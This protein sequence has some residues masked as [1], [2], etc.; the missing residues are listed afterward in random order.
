MTFVYEFDLKISEVYL[1]TQNQLSRARLLK[2]RALQ[3][4][5]H[6]ERITT[7][8]RALCIIKLIMTNL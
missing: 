1:H 8:W 7:Y 5:T 6:M 4:G 2:V 3:T